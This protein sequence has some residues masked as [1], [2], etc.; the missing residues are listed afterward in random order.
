MVS[1]QDHSLSCVTLLSTP[2]D[3]TSIFGDPTKFGLAAF[4]IAFDLLFMLQHYVLFRHPH[5]PGKE[6]YRRIGEE[7]EEEEEEDQKEDKVN[8]V[9]EVASDNE[10]A[11]LLQPGAGA[12]TRTRLLRRLLV[13]LHLY[14]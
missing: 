10:E 14:D 5:R 1:S 4:S 7:E 6:G 11:A 12:G 2:D 9:N 8:K 3:W 13:A